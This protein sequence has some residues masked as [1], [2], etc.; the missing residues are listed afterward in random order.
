MAE[1]ENT[2]KESK[3]TEDSLRGQTKLEFIEGTVTLPDKGSDSYEQ[4]NRCDFIVISWILNSI[5][6]WK[7]SL[8]SQNSASASV[9]F[10]ELKGLWDE[11]G[12]INTLP[13]CTCGASKAIYEIN[14]R[15]R[16][17]Q[18]LMGLNDTYRIVRDQILGMDP[19]P[20]VNKAYFM[21]LK[22]E[23][24]NDILGSM[25]GNTEPLKRLDLKRRL[26][27]YCN[28]DRHVRDGCFKLIGYPEWFKTKTKNNG[29]SFKANRNIGYE[30]RVVAA[31]EGPPNGK[32]TPLDILDTSTQISDL[33]AML[34]SLQQ[35]VNKLIKGKAILTANTQQLNYNNEYDSDANPVAF[36]GNINS[37]SMSYASF[38]KHI[39]WILDTGIT[40][41]MSSNQFLFKFL[42]LLNKQVTVY[43][44]DDN[45]MKVCYIGSIMVSKYMHLENVMFVPKFNYNLLSVSKLI[46]YCKLSLNKKSLT[47]KAESCMSAV[48]IINWH[49][50]LGH[51]SLGKLK[52][53][54]MFKHTEGNPLQYQICPQA[55]QARLPF[56][57]S[58]TIITTDNECEFLSNECSKILIERKY[59]HILDMARAIKIHSHSP[60][61]CLYRKVLDYF[62]LKKFGCLCFATK[63]NTHKNKFGSKSIKTAFIGYASNHKAYKLY[64][65]TVDTIFVSRVIAFYEHI[66][67]FSTSPLA[68]TVMLPIPIH[69][70][71]HVPS[72][73]LPSILSHP[74]SFSNPSAPQ[75]SSRVTKPPWLKDFVAPS[76]IFNKNTYIL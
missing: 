44:P 72:L 67:P 63:T 53:I 21:V 22:F 37:K 25:N 4:W 28:M 3:N 39:N 2:S 75:M 26:C 15:N 69:D 56:P 42:E 31:I 65:L 62:Y 49:D 68:P 35:E 66:F 54:E 43:L 6:K 57:L 55:K 32:D 40:D 34:S 38:H 41:H 46:K 13:P 36:V 33:N 10:I 29:Q 9:Y 61:E 45:A 59:R 24:Q 76:C 17:M 7:I 50:R 16:L 19:I 18:F 48:T 58:H 11:L 30:R 64:N 27:S 1:R 20:S 52:H 23:S 74:P 47:F 70:L 12:S 5:S 60:Y 71:E 14:N 51:A 8:I 73:P